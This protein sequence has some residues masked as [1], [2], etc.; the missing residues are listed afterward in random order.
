[1]GIMLYSA[2]FLIAVTL[3][4]GHMYAGIVRSSATED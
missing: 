2:V 1:M 4:I 3:Q